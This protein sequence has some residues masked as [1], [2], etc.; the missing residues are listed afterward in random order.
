MNTLMLMLVR[1]TVPK[2]VR[3][4]LY[5]WHLHRRIER[6][7]SR[8]FIAEAIIPA[9]AQV[10]CETM[11]FVGVEPYNRKCLRT[12]QDAG[13][14][15]WTI[16][17]DPNAARWGATGRHIV[18]DVCLI[19]R[20]ISS[21]TFD[22]VIINGVFGYGITDVD[23]AEI[24]ISALAKVLK[25]NGILV[26]GGTQTVEYWQ[27]PSTRQNFVSTSLGELPT[28]ID[29]PPDAIQSDHHV[30]DFYRRIAVSKRVMGGT[31]GY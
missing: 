2:R 9:L 20:L 28:H 12:C 22:A 24:A 6:L 8:R 19:D 25:K 10:G 1:A 7:S 31:I 27:L 11:L 4:A 29:F 14:V 13:I 30:Y 17:V 18:G 3:S 5:R 16:D 23:R 26:I 15:V 21:L